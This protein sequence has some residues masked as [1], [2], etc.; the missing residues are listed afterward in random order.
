LNLKEVDKPIEVIHVDGKV[1]K[2]IN[3]RYLS[4]DSHSLERATRYLVIVRKM[5]DDEIP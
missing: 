3:K 2:P 1:V 5:S 4:R